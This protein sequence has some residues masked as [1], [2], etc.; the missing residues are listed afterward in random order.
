MPVGKAACQRVRL[1]RQPERLEQFH[2]PAAGDLFLA[3][4]FRTAQ[5]RAEKSVL[6]GPMKSDRDVVQ[7]REVLK[8]A[9]ILERPGNPRVVD[10]DRRMAFDVFAVQ[11]DRAAVR[12]VNAG[13]DIERRRLARAVGTDQAGKFAAVQREIEIRQGFQTAELD[14]NVGY[15]QK[16]HVHTAGL[17]VRSVDFENA[18]LSF[19]RAIMISS[20]SSA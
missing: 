15:F 10:G 3:E 9:D 17:T 19:A 2:R 5:Q 13:D 7:D 4:I 6:G 20:T 11:P 8:Q 12:A 16:A 1:A 14:R 18:P